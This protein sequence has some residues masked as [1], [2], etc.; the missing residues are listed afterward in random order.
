MQAVLSR[1][2]LTEYAVLTQFSATNF[3]LI[4]YIMYDILTTAL[5]K[6]AIFY[7]NKTERK[8]GAE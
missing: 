5:K 3:K 8:N 7:E 1:P 6:E 4:L 2:P